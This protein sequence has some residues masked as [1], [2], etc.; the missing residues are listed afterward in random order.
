MGINASHNA[1]IFACQILSLKYPYLREKI[2]SYKEALEKEVEF[3]D[4]KLKNG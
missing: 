3:E 2:R 4:L 1:G